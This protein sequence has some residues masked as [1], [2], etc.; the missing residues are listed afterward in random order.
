MWLHVRTPGTAAKGT[1]LNCSMR[2]LGMNVTTLYFVFV[3]ALLTKSL[4]AMA[5]LARTVRLVGS[6]ALHVQQPMAE[7]RVTGTRA[8][9]VSDAEDWLALLL[10]RAVPCNKLVSLSSSLSGRCSMQCCY[11]C[12]EGICGHGDTTAQKA[13]V[14]SC[15]SYGNVNKKSRIRFRKRHKQRNTL[16]NA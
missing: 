1:H 10:V 3:I 7:L 6:G 15:R 9:E 12:K 16:A 2:F 8:T 14:G 4:L 13:A 5:S 11:G